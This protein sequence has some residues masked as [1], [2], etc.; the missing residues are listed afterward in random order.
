MKVAEKLIR[1]LAARMPF[2]MRLGSSQPFLHYVDEPSNRA[3]VSAPYVQLRGW[4]ATR[5]GTVPSDL[6]LSDCVSFR[7]SLEMVPRPDVEA[8][9]PR[10]SAFGFQRLFSTMDLPRST[11]WYVEFVLDGTAQRLPVNFSID[12]FFLENFSRQKRDKLERIK[13]V[14]QC[15]VC[16]SADLLEAENGVRCDSCKAFY[17]TEESHFDFLSEELRRYGGVE[18]TEN[19]SANRYDSTATRLIEELKDGLILDNGCGLRDTY[20][21][22]VVNFE[23]VDYPTTDVMG[24]GERLPF[25]PASFD[26]VFSLSVLEHVKDPFQCA[27]EILRVLK[28]GGTLYV[29][30]PFLQPFHGYP[31]HYYNMTTSGLKNLFP[32]DVEILECG[33]LD[34][35]LPIWCLSW[36]LRSYGSGLPEEVAE[37]FKNMRLGDLM[38]EPLAYMERDFVRR[39]SPQTNEELACAIYLLARKANGS[40]EAGR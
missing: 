34:A 3:V 32:H 16:D 22:N 36:F 6:T 19:I 5:K 11:R 24:V 20:F 10:Y 2:S 4:I 15:P 37:E 12:P 25:R 31:N 33:V 1:A 13:T 18:A 28:P 35:G 39:L 14:L 27:R 9:Y 7:K 23:I 38:S 26:A 8:V 30:V 21:S 17:R 40:D 29:A